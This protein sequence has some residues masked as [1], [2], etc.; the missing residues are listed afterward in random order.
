MVT[1]EDWLTMFS[2]LTAPM[3]GHLPSAAGRIRRRAHRLQQ[4]LL[5]RLA[6]RQAQG[7]VTIVGIE[8][9]VARLQSHACGYQQGLVAGAGDLEK[10]LLLPLEQDLPIVGAA[11]QIHQPVHPD[12]LLRLQTGVGR[13]GALL[14]T[15]CLRHAHLSLHQG[16]KL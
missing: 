9:V 2:R 10:D 6:Q 13:G 8:P 1:E 5:H 14:G 16:Y 3:R 15:G 11:R 4:L 7:T 12:Q